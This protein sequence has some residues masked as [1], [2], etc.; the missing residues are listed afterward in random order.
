MKSSAEIAP[1]AA[2]MSIGEAAARFGLA[3]HVLRHWES[4]GLLAPSRIAG[5]RR[6]YA[7]RELY[8]IAMI[9]RAKEGGFTLEDIRAMLIAPGP[10][11]RRAI[12]A[13][14]RAELVR[15]IEEAR[16]SL[17]LIDHALA[18]DADDLALCPRFRADLADL[19]GLP[20]P[21]ARD[22]ALGFAGVVGEAAPPRPNVN[23]SQNVSPRS[24]T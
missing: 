22:N 19:A 17:A 24:R 5:D 7:P 23:A 1:D 8:R 3:T 2:P 4:M 10:A 13:A 14:R 11:E 15:R 20:V 6:R 16:A 12:L 9:L 18:C 21:V